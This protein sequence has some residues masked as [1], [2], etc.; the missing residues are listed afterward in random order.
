MSEKIGKQMSLIAKALGCH[1]TLRQAPIT[2]E[3]IFSEECLLAAFAKRADQLCS[4]CIGYGL[5]VTF[6]E[7]QSTGM[8]AKVKFDEATPNSLR[9]LCM[10]DVLIEIIQQAPSREATPLDDLM[11][12]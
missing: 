8:G 6:D 1:F 5:G 9:L 4:F 2:P 11:Y 10:T 7:G 3:K 12:D